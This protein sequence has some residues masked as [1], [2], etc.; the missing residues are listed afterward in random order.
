MKEPDPPVG[1]IRMPLDQAQR[2]ELVDDAA[3]RDRLNFQQV[4]QAALIDALVVRQIG[5]H[6][7]LRARQAGAARVLLKA[8][9]Q[10]PRDVMQQKSKCRRVRFHD[11]SINKLAYDKLDIASFQRCKLLITHLG[12]SVILRGGGIWFQWCL[13]CWRT[14]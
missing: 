14:L 8:S 1:R 5:Q 12:R 2:L 7:P 6:L 3:K 13:E 4:S 9:P 10:Q 11:S